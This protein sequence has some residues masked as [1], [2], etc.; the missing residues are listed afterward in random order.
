MEDTKCRDRRK[1]FA[2]TRDGYCCILSRTYE[3]D[4]QCPFQKEFVDDKAVGRRRASDGFI[5]NGDDEGTGSTASK[6]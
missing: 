1:C 5:S 3:E 6:G 4:G 2:K